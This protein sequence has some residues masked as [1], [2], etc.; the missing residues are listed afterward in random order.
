MTNLSFPRKK[1]T[2][3]F[4]N[5]LDEIEEEIDN[6]E[7]ETNIGD[8]PNSIKQSVLSK[9]HGIVDK[10][11][12]E[13]KPRLRAVLQSWDAEKYL[14]LFSQSVEKATIEFGNLES[15]EAKKISGRS[16]IN[17][18]NIKIDN[19]MVYNHTTKEIESKANKNE[20]MVLK[21]LRR[22]QHI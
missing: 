8:V 2:E 16:T 21:Q 7:V 20:K 5:I 10:H 17:T 13:I 15:E 22:L 4:Q 11:L 14:L 19:K 18:K 3:Q 9:F 6:M 12:E 1:H